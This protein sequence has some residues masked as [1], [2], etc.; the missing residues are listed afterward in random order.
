MLDNIR[1]VLVAT[2]EPGNIGAVA[3]AMKNMCLQNLVLVNPAQFPHA[4]ATARASGADDLLA[5]AQV[6]N[7][8]D[9]ALSGC[10]LVLGA[11]A[12][13][14]RLTWPQV[15]ARQCAQKALA[16]AIDSQVAIV[17]GREHSGL[18]NEELER[19]HYLVHIPSNEEYSSLNVA[20]AVQVITYELL[21]ADKKASV[22]A[23]A[24]KSPE[25][26]ERLATADEMERL[27]EHMFE[28]LQQ[29]GFLSSE[30]PRKMM[31]RL[32]R[33]FNKAAV[34]RVELNILRGIFATV[35][36]TLTRN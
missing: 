19:C 15:D 14:R 20:A 27:F 18:T 33:L 16:A 23:S 8:L 3:R 10:A 4:K 22:K 12:R 21:M 32:R 9:E 35:Q 1:I 13:L 31:R 26:E 24:Q 2:S 17:F 29:I 5:K 36:K 34:D 6:C 11:S 30:H 25:S 28:V 7:S